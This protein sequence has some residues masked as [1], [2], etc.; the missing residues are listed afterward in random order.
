MED[1]AELERKQTKL[2]EDYE[3]YLQDQTKNGRDLYN[4]LIEQLGN[5]YTQLN[6]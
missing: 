2:Q 1:I 4:L 5:L 6:H 3:D